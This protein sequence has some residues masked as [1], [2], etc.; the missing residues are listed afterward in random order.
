MSF[1]YITADHVGTETGGGVV[2]AN[3][4]AALGRLSGSY[5]LCCR[6]WLEFEHQSNPVDWKDPWLW[7]QYVVRELRRQES[8][9]KPPYKLAHLYAGTFTETVKYLKSHGTKVSY[10]AAAHSI[11]ASKQAHTD[12]GLPFDYHHLTDPLQWEKYVGG[13]LAAD[14]VICPSTHSKQCMEGYGCKNVVVIPHGCTLPAEIKPPPSRF[15]VGYLGSYGADKG[16][17]WLLEAWKKLNYSLDEAVLVLAGRD[18]VSP[19]VDEMV[20][21]YFGFGGGTRSNS[22]QQVGW[23]KNVSDFYNSIS[24]YVQPSTTEG[25]GIEVLE[26]MAHGR[27]AVCSK[28]AGAYDLVADTGAGVEVPPR[29]PDRIVGAIAMY[30]SRPDLWDRWA[31]KAREEAEYHTWEIV[32]QKYVEAWRKLLA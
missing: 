4:V 7:D 28:G 6:G 19:F 17:R 21:R 31:A 25:F 13:Y 16:V 22:I 30:K 32:Q 3:E 9:G 8:V 18:S 2:T 15:V 10:T 1:L 14:L 5:G 24:L 12:L 27:Q 29:S 11:E 23:V 26:A 20:H